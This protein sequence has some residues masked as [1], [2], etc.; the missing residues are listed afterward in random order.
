MK[1]RI[2][3]LGIVL[4]LLVAMVIPA[5]ALAQ[6]QEVTG[7]TAAAYTISTTVAFGAMPVSSTKTET[8]VITVTYDGSIAVSVA[9]TSGTYVA[10]RL[11]SLEY[12]DT[13]AP[14]IGITAPVS[15]GVGTYTITGSPYAVTAGDIWDLEATTGT[16]IG[17]WENVAVTI[18]VT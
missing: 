5:T 11:I 12:E 2:L 8:G 13:G 18:T 3:T 1:R 14:T 4:A 7:E 6:A 15:D 10:G 16:N 9:D 17:A